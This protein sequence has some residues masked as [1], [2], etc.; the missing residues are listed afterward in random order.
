MRKL[1]LVVS[2]FCLALFCV[3]QAASFERP[4]QNRSWVVS[5]PHIWSYGTEIW[6]D[7][8]AF[9]KS[10]GSL[11]PAGAS[12]LSINGPAKSY[13]DQAVASRQ[14]ASDDMIRCMEA[15]ELAPLWGV[16]AVVFGPGAM[17]GFALYEL[18]SAFD[19][20]PYCVNYRNGYI[21]SVEGSL[22]A[23]EQSISDSE[24]SI[25]RARSSYADISFMGLCDR[26]YSG[27]GSEPCAE[28]ASAFSAVDNGVTEG[29]YGKYPLLLSYTGLFSAGLQQSAPDLTLFRPMMELAWGEQGVIRSF[30]ALSQKCAKAQKDAEMSFDSLSNHAQD[31]RKSTESQLSELE[32]QRLDLI[33]IAPSGSTAR[34]PGSVAESLYAARKTANNL[35]MAFD[36][37]Q[38]ERTML[39]KTDY[40]ADAINLMAATDAAYGRLLSDL[41]A[42]EDAARDAETQQRAEA[43]TELETTAS[44]I[45]S[46]KGSPESAAIFS[47][48]KDAFEKAG[49]ASKTGE[50]FDG[51]RKAAA[52]ARSARSQM[53]YGDE[54]ELRI[55]MAELEDLI[56]RAQA[57]GVNVVTEAETL[58]LLKQM[59]SYAVADQA[60]DAIYNI[61][62]KARILYDQPLADSH[63]RIVDKLSLAGSGASD[64]YTDLER[65]E[66][67]VYTSDGMIDYPNAIGKLK[68][69][70]QNYNS[71]EK[72]LDAYM[73]DI[74][75]NAMSVSADPLIT[76]VMLDQP[77][78]I[79]LDAV[80]A[81]PRPYN[82]SNVQT[83]ITMRW[84]MG[85][86]YSDIT[87]GKSGVQSVRSAD[88]GKTIILSLGTVG[89]FESRHVR[90]ER[91]GIVAH[92][93]SYEVHAEGLGDGSASVSENAVFTLDAPIMRLSLSPLSPQ[94][95]SSSS[96]DVL[97]DGLAPSRPLSQG[98]HTI[99]SKLIVRDA[100]DQAAD[101]IHAYA[102]GSNSRVEYRIAITP[103]MDLESALVFIESMNDSRISDPEVVAATGEL[104]KDR[105]RISGTTY[106]VR[107]MD[108][109]KE[110]QTILRVS[111]SVD[112]T[113]S[114][115]NEQISVLE[116]TN[117]SSGA[118]PL[119]DQAKQQADAGNYTKALELL[120]QYRAAERKETADMAKLQAAFADYRK[121]LTSEMAGIDAALSLAGT[122]N[123]TN[124]SGQ[125]IDRLR[126]R[127]SELQR[128]LDEADATLA[129]GNLSSLSTAM[130][131]IDTRW[132]EKEIDSF[133][134]EA[135]KEYNDLKDRFFKAGNSTTPP[136]FIAFEDAFNKLQSNGRPEYAIR[137]LDAL[138]DVRSVVSAQEAAD[139]AA[140][141]ASKTELEALESDVHQVMSAYF[142][143]AGAAKGTDYASMF[144]ESESRL[145]KLMKDAEAA[146]GKDSRILQLRME[147]LQKAKQGMELT[148]G[149]LKDESEAKLSLLQQLVGD[150]KLDDATRRKLEERL[151][152]IRGMIASGDYVNALR[153][154][155]VI[156]RDLESS[157]KS[158]DKS[159]LLLGITALAVLAT[160]AAYLV[161]H[162]RESGEG[163]GGG[164]KKALRRLERSQGY[165]TRGIRGERTESES[166]AGPEKPEAQNK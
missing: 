127:K 50:R 91:Q 42:L 141:E 163:K 137:V 102:L 132:L 43:Q 116:G 26:G 36:D 68:A 90:F 72:T 2:V 86:L 165:K 81:N 134:K 47:D 34:M 125:L 101:D 39:Y 113:A 109:S 1:V 25:S 75:G 52:L 136:E 12:S 123:A 80:L 31:R 18:V 66:A 89:P 156:S 99:S 139:K 59:P 133:R 144:I 41:S 138:E 46:G 154:G 35:S 5:N 135:Y 4:W 161:K 105:R 157:A 152:A 160:L 45:S 51:Y 79:A 15:D 76:N 37:A 13:I 22:D 93:T 74:V 159:L 145:S 92:T 17:A 140:K 121:K 110:K 96:G 162:H 117:M 88:G 112:N 57:D 131:K 158:D 10:L 100:Y 126:A 77:A 85:F 29:G 61:I 60:R 94:Q 28:L 151:T 62:A 97:I 16:G 53:T 104:V 58:K 129:S 6:W 108:L 40:L 64:L 73:A 8:N 120:E 55:S 148:L 33:N 69:L 71:L 78:D 56:K 65:Y 155:S 119:F 147:D 146:V 38:A 111:Y 9:D 3:S 87:L 115:V 128:L 106:S 54:L 143:E 67:G 14:Q 21:A 24:A 63:A 82:A 164:M 49:S 150:A 166:E 84:P 11:D 118:R 98:R 7:L 32:S 142:K 95:L 44:F 83:R 130:A 48:A 70:Q 27:A 107:V 124:V 30:D 20:I 149:S 103:V 153:A 122:G 114:L 23:L 19:R